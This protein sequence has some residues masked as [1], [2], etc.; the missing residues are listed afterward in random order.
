MC[1]HQHSH[2]YTCIPYIP[3][4]I[5]MTYQEGNNWAQGAC[6][7]RLYKRTCVSLNLRRAEAPYVCVYIHAWM[8][9]YTYVCAKLDVN[10]HKNVHRHIHTYIRSVVRMR[11]HAS[12]KAPVAGIWHCILLF[13]FR[14]NAVQRV[15]FVACVCIDMYTHIYTHMRCMDMQISECAQTWYVCTIYVCT[16]MCTACMYARRA[17]A[18]ET[19][20]MA[21]PSR[22]LGAPYLA[23]YLCTCMYV[24]MYVS[25]HMYVRMFWCMYLCVYVCMYLYICMFACFDVCMC[26]CIVC[27][28]CMYV[29]TYVWWCMCALIFAQMDVS[30]CVCEYARGYVCTYASTHTHKYIHKHTLFMRMYAYM[31]KTRVYKCMRT[32]IP[33]PRHRMQSYHGPHSLPSNKS[34]TCLVS[35]SRN[36][37]CTARPR[38]V[39]ITES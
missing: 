8:Y 18:P 15:S 12:I 9:I 31:Q 27:I 23:Q 33:T 34:L 13:A 14:T 16:C 38:A 26:V 4:Y 36:L 2:T 39:T 19:N 1:A 10:T 17:C 30:M 35:S 3:T 24:C 29:R 5:H 21:P 6:W 7:A 37:P 11:A 20:T 28:V 22:S 32:S 25:V